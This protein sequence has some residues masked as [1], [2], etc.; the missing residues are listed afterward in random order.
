MGPELPP[1]IL[2]EAE[3]KRERDWIAYTYRSP[4]IYDCWG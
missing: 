1:L 4:A 3:A 2:G